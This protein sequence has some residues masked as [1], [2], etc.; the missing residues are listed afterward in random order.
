[1]KNKLALIIGYNLGLIS[2]KKK[3]WIYKYSV[4][5]ILYK[6]NMKEIELN[7]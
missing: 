1:M 2:L 7:E 4:N 6:G 5:S 3:E